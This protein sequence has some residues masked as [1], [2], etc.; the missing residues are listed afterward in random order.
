MR[1]TLTHI[2]LGLVLLFGSAGYS[3]AEVKRVRMHIAGY[4]CGN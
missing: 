1:R 3:K 4:L 2:S